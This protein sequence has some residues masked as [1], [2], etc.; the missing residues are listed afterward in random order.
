MLINI[1]GIWKY[2]SRPLYRLELHFFM[3]HWQLWCC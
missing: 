2:Y 3:Q 1:L